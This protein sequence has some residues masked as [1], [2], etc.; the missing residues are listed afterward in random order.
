MPSATH[1]GFAYLT[2]NVEQVF[3]PPNADRLLYYPFCAMHEMGNI[4][5]TAGKEIY[6]IFMTFGGRLKKGGSWGINQLTRN[7]IG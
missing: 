4:N 7:S 2:L 5:V 6:C 1:A 3:L